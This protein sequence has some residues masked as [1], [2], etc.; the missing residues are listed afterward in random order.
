MTQPLWQLGIIEAA[1]AYRSGDARPSEVLLSTLERIGAVNPTL[2]AFAVLDE[3]GARAAAAASDARWGSGTALGPLDGAVLSIKDNITVAGLPCGWGS[4]LFAGFVP[5][6]DELPVARL[7]AAGAV[8][9]GKTTVSEF[10]MGRGTVNTPVYGATRNP[11]A[12]ALTTGASSG[13]ACAAVASGMGAGA[14]GT[15]GGGSI[16]RPASHCGLVGL[17]PST[18][19]VARWDGLPVVLHDCEVVGPIARTVADLVALYRGIAGPDPRDRSS[20]LVPDIPPPEARR[21]RVLYV[22][23]FGRHP[24]DPAVAT[25]CN[26]AAAALADLGCDVETGDAPFDLAL[27]EAHWPTISAAGLARLMQ[28]RDWQGHVSQ[29]HAALI[30][31]GLSLAA[32]EYVAA[33]AGF[34]T[35]AG[36]LGLFFET[37]DLLMTP[38]CGVPPWPVEQEAPPSERVFTGFV[39]AA[40]LPAIGLPTPGSKPLPIGFQLVARFGADDLLLRTAATYEASHRWTLPWSASAGT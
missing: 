28:G 24:V 35:L 29:H 21:L 40:G 10:T 8:L 25:A 37:F 36:Q 27:H 34:R 23:Q 22:P 9:L 39:N 14:L 12:P 26:A 38:C 16:R 6:R 13:G 3:P 5:Q 18:G 2:N 32:T 20:W 4:A 7:R 30:E 31:K 15:D 33:L 11:W 17:K 1:D 19:R